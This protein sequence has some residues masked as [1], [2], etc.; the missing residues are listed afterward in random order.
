M[1][2]APPKPEQG[3]FFR[4]LAWFL[5]RFFQLL[6]HQFAW[7]YDLVAWT[8]SL[9]QWNTWIRSAIPYLHSSLV[10]EL[11]H[12]PGH[13]QVAFNQA[14][15]HSIGIDLSKQM[16]RQA[17]H[18]MRK[19][20]IQPN[21]IYAR[22]QQLPLPSETIPQIVATFPSEYIS[23]PRSLNEMHRVLVPGGSVIILLFAWITGQKAQERFAAWLFRVTGESPIWEDAFLNPARVVGF[24]A[25]SEFILLPRSKL[26]LLHLQKSI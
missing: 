15:V 7:A 22:T 3:F 13:L 19:M 5:R 1:T 25:H 18:R 9:G 8:V 24:V 21:L 20:H 26:L 4:L 2:T 12:G 14:G 17:C 11:G 10:L 16:N 6:Y 23:D